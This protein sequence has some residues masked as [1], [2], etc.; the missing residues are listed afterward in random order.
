MKFKRYKHG[1]IGGVWVGFIDAEKWTLFVAV[2][3]TAHLHE[4]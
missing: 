4:K 3:G 1:P 2:D